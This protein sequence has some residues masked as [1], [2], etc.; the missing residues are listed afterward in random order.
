[1][2]K[3]LCIFVFIFCVG[4]AGLPI[5]Q[6]T[7]SMNSQSFISYVEKTVKGAEWIKGVT[8]L[9]MVMGCTS[10]KVKQKTCDK[11]AEFSSYSSIVISNVKKSIET[12]KLDGTLVSQEQ[13]N[14]ALE[15]L[16]RVIFKLDNVYKTPIEKIESI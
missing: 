8:D 14:L 15:E 7:T 9:G 16:F 12:Y 13:V 4:C 1:M 10:G 5:Q 3:L 2:K 6:D 11:Y